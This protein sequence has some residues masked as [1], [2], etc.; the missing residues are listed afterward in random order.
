MF[1]LATKRMSSSASFISIG[2]DK[3]WDKRNDLSGYFLEC[4]L[5][6]L[7]ETSVP[8][9]FM[10]SHM[11]MSVRKLVIRELLDHESPIAA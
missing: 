8:P 10:Q 5:H 2:R 7:L 1:Y 4:S 9:H 6:V 3:N 11:G